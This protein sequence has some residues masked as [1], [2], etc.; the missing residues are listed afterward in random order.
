[1]IKGT[2]KLIL[3][4]V[5]VLLLGQIRVSGETVGSHVERRATFAATWVGQ[6]VISTKW[7]KSVGADRFLAQWVATPAK[8]IAKPVEASL[9]KKKVREHITSEDRK[10][11]LRLL[12]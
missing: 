9:V 12:E 6:W 4:C 5:V 10:A 2:L 11:I 7:A 8:S 3:F 1:M